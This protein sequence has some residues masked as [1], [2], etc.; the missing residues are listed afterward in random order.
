MP[1]K[2]GVWFGLIV[3]LVASCYAGFASDNKKFK[4]G[5]HLKLSGGPFQ[6]AVGDMNTHL[7]SLND[8]YRRYYQTEG[9]GEIR[10]L[11]WS[12]EWELEL[13]WDASSKIRWG[14]A[15]NLPASRTK[16][17]FLGADV[18][19]YRIDHEIIF[20]PQINVVAPVRL[21]V[22]YSVF[23]N[24]KINILLHSGIGLYSTKMNEEQIRNYIFPAET[25][26][27][28]TAPGP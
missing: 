6:A 22:Y 12:N 26:T 16:V 2:L 19:E 7:H 9:S 28:A 17:L 15:T 5:F 21:S 18:R 8:Y 4:P 11:R 3:F 27:L 10:T 25:S 20:R 1:K 13:L 24:A 14:L 23:S